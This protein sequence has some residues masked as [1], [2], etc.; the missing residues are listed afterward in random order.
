MKSFLNPSPVK[1]LEQALGWYII[2]AQILA[3][4]EPSRWL[5][6]AILQSVFMDFF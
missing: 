4:I 1:D 5:Y 2:Y 3:L 6:M